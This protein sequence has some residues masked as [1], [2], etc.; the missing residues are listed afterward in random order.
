MKSRCAT[1]NEPIE[2]RANSSAQAANKTRS[3]TESPFAPESKCRA[4][5]A[6]AEKGYADHHIG[7]VMELGDRKQAQQQYFKG[8]RSCRKQSDGENRSAL[9]LFA[10]QNVTTRQIVECFST[11]GSCALPGQ[12]SPVS[13]TNRTGRIWRRVVA[14]DASLVIKTSC[15][16]LKRLPTG[17]I[18]R[19]P[20]LSCFT[21]AGGTWLAAAVTTMASKGP[22]SSQP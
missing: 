17:M 15:C 22:C 12:C 14:P 1:R 13:G 8:Q 5:G 4:R 11:V 21:S 18:M 20:G 9:C 7:E 16:T 3:E 10:V 19:P 2:V 6:K